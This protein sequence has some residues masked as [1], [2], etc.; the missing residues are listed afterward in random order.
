MRKFW[1]RNKNVILH[2]LLIV[3]GVI[4]VSV[5]TLLILQGLDI[6]TFDGEMHFNEEKFAVFQGAW[7][8]WIFFILLQT[9]LSMLLCVIPGASM[10]F[11][12][13]FQTI[14]TIPWQNFLVCF[15]SV[16]IASFSMYAAG[17]FGGYPLCEKLMGKEDCERAL[18]LLR[19]KGTVYF[20]FM[21]L[22]PFFPDEA[23]TM[24]AGTIK[25]PLT[26]FAPSI[27]VARGIG[28]ATIVFGL[29]S[30]PFDKFT[31]WWHW[32]GFILGCAIVVAGVLI[33]AGR[34]NK[35]MEKRRLESEETGKQ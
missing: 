6:V 27:F 13:L 35:F 28:I 3:G 30:I 16:S 2:S 9:V 23:L 25:M 7:Y 1:E 34:F 18:G 26:W 20:P 33:F 11:I 19:N 8:G 29:S 10:A 5:I 14:F 32:V 22:F 15:A 4:A 12:L 31:S 17:R 21:M 24:V